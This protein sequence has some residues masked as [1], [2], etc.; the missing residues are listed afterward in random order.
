MYGAV[1]T[2]V[3]PDYALNG[4]RLKGCSRFGIGRGRRL[5]RRNRNTHQDTP[6]RGQSRRLT[7][8]ALVSDGKLASPGRDLR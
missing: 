5:R 8:L 3:R 6:R 2:G 1:L 4:R 7:R